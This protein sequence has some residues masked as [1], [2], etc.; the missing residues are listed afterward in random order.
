MES[1]RLSEIQTDLP[2]C[3]SRYRSTV[4]LTG[5]NLRPG[6]LT[7]TGNAVDICNFKS[8]DLILD[9]GCGHGMTTRY[10]SDI[11]GI[12]TVGVD[13]NGEVLISAS[14]KSGG[15]IPFARS[16]LPVLPFR[17]GAFDG[18]FCEC[19]LSQVRQKAQ[20][21][22]EFFRL[23]RPNGKLVLADVFMPLLF[24]S[25]FTG[26]LKDRFEGTCLSGTLTIPEL[27]E[28]LEGAGFG[29]EVMEGHTR[30]LEQMA[31]SMIFQ[32]ACTDH[33]W[34]SVREIFA[35]SDMDRAGPTRRPKPG[36][37]MIIAG[38]FQ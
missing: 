12:R 23:L 37:C 7:L 36:Y 26:D 14:R 15:K 6:G 27:I 20:C 1:N 11:H 29:I 38:K 3:L 35:D 30:L 19:V 22:K 34:K 32:N 4:S 25:M 9:A 8:G 17:S 21:L 18:I 33:L 28:A 16:R 31:D 10:L 5:L 24:T 2:P 13:F